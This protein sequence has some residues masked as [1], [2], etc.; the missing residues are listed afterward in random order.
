MRSNRAKVLLV[1]P[2]R[3][4]NNLQVAPDLGLLF[5]ATTLRNK[6]YNVTLLDC[7]KHRMS[8]ADFKKYLAS[9][10]FNI[11]GLRCY[12]RDHNY[13]KHHL[14]IVRR[15][16]PLALTLVGGPHPSA[17]PE[18]VLDSM[19]D[20]DFAWKAEAEQGLPKLLSL[21]EEYGRD[22]PENLLGFIPGLVWRS[23][24]QQKTVVNSPAF[25]A[26]LDACGIPDWD[27][28]KPS[29]Y[30]GFIYEEHC[31]LLTTRGCP[32]PCTYCNTPGLS[33]KKLRHRSIKNVIEELTMLKNRYG[34]SRF[35]VA[36]DEFTLDQSY[37]GQF[38]DDLIKADLKLRW[39]CPIGVR[40]DSLNP[41]L[42]QKMQ[43]SGCECIAVGIE[44]GSERIQKLIQKGVTVEKI[45]QQAFMVAQNSRI[46]MI[47]Y[48]ML[49]FWD[50]TEDEV[51]QTIDFAAALPLYRAHFNIVIPVPGTGLFNEMLRKQKIAIEDINWDDCTGDKVSFERDKISSKRLLQLHRLAYLRFYGRPR[52]LWQLGKETLVNR[53]V[54]RAGIRNIKV[55]FRRPP[56]ET[57]IP[58]YLREADICNL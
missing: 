48:F 46:K 36:D 54:M 44:S 3:E 37:A 2:I 38:C 43:R 30:P 58:L 39:D 16:L 51:I 42:L 31:P 50:E 8:F 1:L 17:L 33:G 7:P 18:F 24:A 19:P 21:F 23:A 10:D 32:Y 6:G 9:D 41:E 26:D 4:G 29:D 12:S 34:I 56:A 40:L 52:I 35:S 28:M 53:Q 47:G 15:V 13:V 49:G 14:K 57:S 45:K 55:L 20:L 25:T 5:L 27:L 22:I 11:V